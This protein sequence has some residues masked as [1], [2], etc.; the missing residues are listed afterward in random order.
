MLVS[1][2]LVPPVKVKL[3]NIFPLE[4]DKKVLGRI[5]FLREE[6]Q[7]VKKIP[8][9]FFESSESIYNHL[10]TSFCILYA[11]LESHQNVIDNDTGEYSQY[12][13]IHIKVEKLV[14]TTICCEKSGSGLCLGVWVLTGR[15]REVG[16]GVL[17]MFCSC[18]FV[19]MWPVC[20]NSLSCVLLYFLFCI[21]TTLE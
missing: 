16:F 2:F 5:Y 21:Y 13:S 6:M 9:L 4:L 17:V 3:L 14:I 8:P 11:L 15:G 20:E 19:W 18:W 12:D 7:C 10:Y 1:K